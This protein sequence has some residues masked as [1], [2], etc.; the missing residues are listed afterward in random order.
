[1]AL[2]VQPVQARQQTVLRVTQLEF[3]ALAILISY[4]MQ[5]RHARPQAAA[6]KPFG[7]LQLKAAFLVGTK[8]KTVK[9]VPQLLVCAPPA[10]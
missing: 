2:N 10:T 4:S 6:L 8:P 5:T 1:M 7:N 9:P 3:V